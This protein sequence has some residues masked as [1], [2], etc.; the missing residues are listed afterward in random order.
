ME[1]KDIRWIQRFQNYR[2]ALARLSEAVQ[3][4]K[5]QQL[6]DLEQQ[7][8]IQSFEFTFDLAWKTLQDFVVEKGY[9]GIRGK[10]NPIIAEA[11][12]KGLLDESSWKLMTQS[13]NITSHT[14]NEEI[15][16]EI[17]ENIIDIYLGLFVQLE[18]RLQLEKITQEKQG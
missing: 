6:S 8:L 4:S 11:F 14:Y 15:A 12:K 1:N 2:K 10:P 17:A 16:D 18:T 5:D 3:L 13:R 7:G 9:E